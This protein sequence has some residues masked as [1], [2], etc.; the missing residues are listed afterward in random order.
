MPFHLPW[1]LSEKKKK[2]KKILVCHKAGGSSL[3]F[4]LPDAIYIDVMRKLSF[5]LLFICLMS[6]T[7]F[8]DALELTYQ[9]IDGEM[10]FLWKNNTGYDTEPGDSGP[11]TLT[12]IPGVSFFFTIDSHWFFRPSVF[13]YSQ[14]LEYLPDRGYTIPVDYSNINSLSVTGLLMQPAAG[15]RWVIA[16][17]HT[18]GV[19]MAP[20]LNVQVPLFGPGK[21]DRGDMFAALIKEFLYWNTSVW[22]YNPLTERF[23]FNFKIELGLPVYNSWLNNDLTFADGLMLNFQ[24]GIRVLAQ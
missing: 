22:Y 11:D 10:G 14:T 8:M 12:F 15:Y 17:R 7:P 23:G 18:F 9:G 2:Y 19:Q 6:Q 13:I 20:A 5:I 16:K 3:L 4:F 1:I 21:D 24:V